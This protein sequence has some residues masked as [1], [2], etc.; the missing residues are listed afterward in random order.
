MGCVD[1]PKVKKVTNN[2]LYVDDNTN[3]NNYHN[4]INDIKLN[5]RST[6]NIPLPFIGFR[7]FETRPAAMW[8][9]QQ[10]LGGVELR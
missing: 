8:R 4:I 9:R 7:N 3:K 6:D 2:I 5:N 1:A 10:P